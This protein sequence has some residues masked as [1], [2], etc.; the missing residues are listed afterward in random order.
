MAFKQKLANVTGLKPSLIPSSYQILGDIML[1]KVPNATQA[2]KNKIARGAM[3]LL[4][5]VRSVC[6][7]KEVK[8]E[9]R[10]PAVKLI[11]GERT[12]TIHTENNVKYHLD[13]SKIMF[14]KGNLNERQRLI[15]KIKKDETIVDMFAGIGYFSL[16]IAKHTK[17]KKI[18]AI[19]KN[20]DAFRFLKNNIQLN[21]LTN[22]QTIWG[23]CKD[24]AKSVTNFADRII[25]G[26]FPDTEEF[27]PYAVRIAKNNAIVHFHNIYSA[28][29]L[30]KKP[31]KQIEEACSQQSC[32]FEVL[33][34]KKVKSYKPGV[35][36]VVVD[37]KIIK[38]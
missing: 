13:V 9:L 1:L 23:D 36:H 35:F 27:L 5:Y 38:E 2:E 33:E 29:D 34:K 28:K 4:P 32:G 15:K 22:V 10:Q 3:L 17:A 31:L 19:E 20:L 16:P 6:E 25:M 7:I 24:F 21:N 11:A 26:Y 18:V 14:S 37:F 8:G 12:E 30:W